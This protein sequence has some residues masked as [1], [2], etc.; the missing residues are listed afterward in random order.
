M[1]CK[2]LDL[3]KRELNMNK[4]IELVE[5]YSADNDSVSIQE[6]HANFDS[7]ADASDAACAALSDAI[8]TCKAACNV[9]NA[10]EVIVDAAFAADMEAA[11]ALVAAQ[12]AFFEKRTPKKE[13]GDSMK[14]T[15]PKKS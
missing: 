2:I 6:L 9:V 15:K 4:H 8:D 5:R 14:I 1:P 10:L 12:K 3:T 13:L 11:D 7:A